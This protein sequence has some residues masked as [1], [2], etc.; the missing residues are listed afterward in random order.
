MIRYTLKCAEGHQFDSWFQNAAAFDALV[1]AHQVACPE[2]GGT[3]VAKSLMTPGVRPARQGAQKPLA[4]VDD[5]EKAIAALKKKVESEGEYV[6]LS[7]VKEARAIHDGDAPERPIYGEAKPK[8][9]IKLIEDGVPVTPLPF[10][11]TRKTN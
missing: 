10:T 11:P 5:R 2:C 7:F 1:A 9:A 3:E 4:P 8:E 6:G